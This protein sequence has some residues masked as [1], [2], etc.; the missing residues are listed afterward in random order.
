M[1]AEINSNP[2]IS[3]IHPA[4][5]LLTP[6]LPRLEIISQTPSRAVWLGLSNVRRRG[7]QDAERR[8]ACGE[9]PVL[10]ISLLGPFG[11]ED[12]IK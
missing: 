7:G 2:L 1:K 12:L 5:T 10:L 6:T 11:S 4:L 8:R 9:D 3:S